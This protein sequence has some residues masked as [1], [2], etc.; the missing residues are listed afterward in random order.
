M[1]QKEVKC[2]LLKHTERHLLFSI[3]KCYT[4]DAA[5]L[6]L[7]QVSSCEPTWCSG[8]AHELVLESL[9]ALEASGLLGGACAWERSYLCTPVLA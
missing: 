2:S 8:C 5:C 1:Q 9:K 7:V 3:A 6:I 4:P